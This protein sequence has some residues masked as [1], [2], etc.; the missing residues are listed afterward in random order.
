MSNYRQQFNS[1]NATS[2][3]PCP[4][5]NIQA[6]LTASACFDSAT[7][8]LSNLQNLTYAIGDVMWYQYPND[9]ATYCATITSL[10]GSGDAVGNAYDTA[11][12]QTPFA[13]GCSSTQ[14][15]Q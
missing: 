9:T 2:S 13:N 7:L 8:A 3:A 4:A 10:S 11:T 1:T 14:C 15:Q 6:T 12:R 5:C